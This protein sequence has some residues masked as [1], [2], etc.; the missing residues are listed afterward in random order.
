LAA[1]RAVIFCQMVDDPSA[2]PEEFP[3]EEDQETERLSQQEGGKECK[4]GGNS[5]GRSAPVSN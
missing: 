3:T 5:K 1:A 4:G 2:E